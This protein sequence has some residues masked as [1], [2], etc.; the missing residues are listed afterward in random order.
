[1]SVSNFTTLARPTSFSL[2]CRTAR[3]FGL[4][5]SAALYSAPY[6]LGVLNEH[7]K[8]RTWQKIGKIVRNL[9]VKIGPTGIKFGQLISYRIDIFPKDF[10]TPLEALQDEASPLT[11]TEV[12]EALR[13]AYGDE[14]AKHFSEVNERPIAAGSVAVVL[15]ART[16]AGEPVAIKVLRPRAARQIHTDLRI[17]ESFSSLLLKTQKFRNLPVANLVDSFS[18]SMLRQCDFAEELGLMIQF[19]SIISRECRIP[20]PYQASS[21]KYSLVM[22]LI[23]A[24]HKIS[25]ED[26]T[27]DMQISAF[28]SLLRDLY[29]MIFVSGIIHCDLHP[30][31][32]GVS[33]D[34][35]VVLYDFG[36]SA[37][38]SSNNRG[39]FRRFFSALAMKDAGNLA[40]SIL[41]D[42]EYYPKNL[43][44]GNLQDSISSILIRYSNKTAGNFSVSGL[45]VEIINIQRKFA[46]RGSG[47]FTAAVWALFVF[48]GLVRR[49][50]PS[51]DFQR[52]AVPFLLDELKILGRERDSNQLGGNDARHTKIAR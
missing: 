51:L 9:L 17:I 1:M 44:F 50:Y 19:H 14:L 49:R 2:A 33:D 29:R 41:D 23:P 5:A 31:N 13:F 37:Q 46:I 3:V 10:L 21:N 48:E 38:L 32:V 22:Q 25:N 36:L 40:Q 30:G 24:K 6:L 18:K 12:A 35:R 16:H 8:D 11:A 45:A 39:I 27:A 20:I 15:K 43:S 26:I 42:A 7:S 47:G 28:S 52:A 34:G 4:C